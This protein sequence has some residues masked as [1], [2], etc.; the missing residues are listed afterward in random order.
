MNWGNKILIGFS[1]FVV[2]ISTMVYVAMKQTNEMVDD[3][4]YEKE[5]KYQGKIDASKNLSALAEKIT[6]HY[7]DGA[8]TIKFPIASI[9][10]N[11]VGTI[12]CLRSS[13]Q[14]RDVNIK[15]APDS[16]GL[17]SL[18]RSL[19]IKG[20]YQLRIDWTNKGVAYFHQQE[21]NIQ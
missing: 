8:I 2:A 4:Y 13:E 17:Q 5:L 7:D 15:L 20:R 18:P 16:N 9:S 14:R 21:L 11:A 1:T 19:F 3:N 6:I 12:E 10:S